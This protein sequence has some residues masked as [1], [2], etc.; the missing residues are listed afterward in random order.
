[1]LVTAVAEGILF[2]SYPLV[3]PIP[4]S[5]I[6]QEHLDGIYSDLAQIFIWTQV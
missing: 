4:L 6:S 1:M 3:R 2:L 5:V